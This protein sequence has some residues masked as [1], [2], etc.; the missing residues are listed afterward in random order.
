MGASSSKYSK[1][2]KSSKSS[3]TSKS[4]KSSKSYK[5]ETKDSHSFEKS[6]SSH[7]PKNIIY[8]S[9]KVDPPF[10]VRNGLSGLMRDIILRLCHL[11]GMQ[12]NSGGNGDQEVRAIIGMCREHSIWKTHS[13]FKSNRMGIYLPKT[14]ISSTEFQYTMELT[15]EG[16]E[17]YCFMNE[18]WHTLFLGTVLGVNAGVF[19]WV[20]DMNRNPLFC[21]GVCLSADTDRC[22]CKGLSN[23]YNSCGLHV[24][25]GIP[26]GQ[27]RS[28]IRSCLYGVRGLADFPLDDTVIPGNADIAVEVDTNNRKMYFFIGEKRMPHAISGLPLQ[29]LALGWSAQERG[30]FISV[31]FRRILTVSRDRS[32]GAEV[33]KYYEF[34]I[35]P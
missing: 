19:R 27:N 22:A 2:S 6:N 34:F 17:K 1:S 12:P 21:V 5:L 35:K 18:N 14:L 7:I 29:P 31:S 13:H 26:P 11:V 8:H 4:S 20:V 32:S 23:V 10:E 25:T 15:P 28:D 24:W 16:G 9:V 30:S 3:K 33:L